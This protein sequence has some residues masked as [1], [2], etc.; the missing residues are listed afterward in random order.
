[1]AAYLATGDGLGNMAAESRA[2]PTRTEP[3]RHRLAGR[4][5]REPRT[6]R[7]CS[8]REAERRDALERGLAVFWLFGRGIDVIFAWMLLSSVLH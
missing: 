1:M 6:G 2:W 4:R 5:R 7:D 8:W 3:A